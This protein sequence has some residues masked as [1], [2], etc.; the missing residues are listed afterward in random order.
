[1]NRFKCKAATNNLVILI[2]YLRGLPLME[3]PLTPII[4]EKE[5]SLAR[6]P[7]KRTQALIVRYL[8]IPAIRLAALMEKIRDYNK[9]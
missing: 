1:M 6:R 3:K 4:M 7:A 9:P 2:N 8:I 5:H